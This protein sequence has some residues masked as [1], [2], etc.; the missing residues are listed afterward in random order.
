MKE[1]ISLTLSKNILS[2][3]D[4]LIDDTIMRN[5]SH[6]IESLLA[7]SLNIKKPKTAFILAGGKGT[8]LR[9]IT[10]ELPK[11]MIPVNGRPLLEHHIE[12]LRDADIRDIIISIGYLGDK[13]KEYF[14]NGSKFG[15]KIRYVEEKE[16]LGTA[17]PLRL[18]KDLV[19]EAFIM[20]NGDEYKEIDFVDMFEFHKSQNVLATIGL[21]TVSNPENYGVV[22]MRGS[23]IVGFHEKPKNPP[24]N[25]VNAGIYVLEPD[26][27]SLIPEGFC[28]IEE[29]IFEKLA[30][31]GNKMAGYHFE[32]RWFDLGTMDRYEK[33]LRELGN[34]NAN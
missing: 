17:G 31:Q 2:K 7:K 30:P 18:I 32:G 26:I 1:R 23:K 6:A 25:L 27:I 34:V 4:S 8:R 5:R 12:M 9:P 33:A 10:Y 29:G 20:M 3:V 14:G 28:K 21:I 24:S 19:S 22:E 15:V 16:E 11:P 13:I